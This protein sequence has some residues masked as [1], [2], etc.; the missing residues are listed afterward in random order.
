MISKESFNVFIQKFKDT[1]KAIRTLENAFQALTESNMS[2]ITTKIS[3]LVN[4]TPEIAF[5]LL[6]NEA[7]EMVNFDVFYEDFCSMLSY[8]YLHIEITDGDITDIYINSWD[9]F[10]DFWKKGGKVNEY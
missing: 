8:G 3:S 7:E 5:A 6:G 4:F 10:Y 9:E 1:Q 2:L